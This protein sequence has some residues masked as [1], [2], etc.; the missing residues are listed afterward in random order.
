MLNNTAAAF[1]IFCQFVSA[2]AKKVELYENNIVQSDL[3]NR[4]TTEASVMN[5]FIDV[6]GHEAAQKLTSFTVAKISKI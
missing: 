1:K 6:S 5:T 2:T 4:D 3:E